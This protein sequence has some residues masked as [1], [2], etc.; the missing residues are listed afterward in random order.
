[1]RCG[2]DRFSWSDE[3]ATGNWVIDTQHHRLLELADLLAE[4]LETGRSADVAAEA[5]AA[6][7]SYTRYHFAEEEAFFASIRAPSL[8][9][10]RRMHASLI[11]DV[12]SMRFNLV[13]HHPGVGAQLARWVM[14]CLVPH[15]QHEDTAAIAAIGGKRSA[16]RAQAAADE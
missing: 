16:P 14:T 5:L 15:M 4:A 9:K 2:V 1:M 3:Y 12:E 11:L 6:L 7:E 10:H 8:A 13:S